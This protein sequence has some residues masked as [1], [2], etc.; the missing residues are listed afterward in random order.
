[1]RGPGVA[2]LKQGMLFRAEGQRPWMVSHCANPFAEARGGDRFRVY[3]G[4]RDR[5]NRTH[6]GWLD[7]D[8]GERP[9]VVELAEEPVLGPGP[10]GA[11]DDSGTSMGC[12]VE[13]GG[14]RFLYY[15]GWNLGVTVPWRNFIGLA[16]SASPDAPF[17]KASPAPVMDRSAE[18]PFNL[19]YPWVIRE[20]NLWRMWYGSNRSWGAGVAD[21]DHVIKYAESD[22]GVHWRRS[23]LTAI[24]L[25]PAGEFAVCRPCVVKTPGGY[26]MWYGRRGDSY[27]IGYAR[28]A[29]GIHWQRL[30][31]QSGIDVSASGWDSEMI[32]YPCVF[33]HRGRRYMLYGGNDY[34]RAGF[35]LALEA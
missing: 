2:W 9:R 28:S 30:D 34:T 20:D 25:K 5:D 3:F 17:I 29:D 26:E 18:D 35:G 10:R 33:V 19:T 27:R 12:V 13:S 22:D 11:F 32:Q 7:L 16:V 6:I 21:A 31:E 4:S 24:D 15:L 23:G 8:L 14:R 1:M